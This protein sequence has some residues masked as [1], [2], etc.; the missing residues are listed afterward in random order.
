M[1]SCF[2][3][4]L[5]VVLLLQ[6]LTIIF[7]WFGL[8]CIRIFIIHLLPVRSFRTNKDNFWLTLN[9][10]I[11]LPIY[12]LIFTKFSI[13]ACRISIELCKIKVLYTKIQNS[14][15]FTSNLLLTF[16]RL[17]MIKRLLVSGGVKKYLK[18]KSFKVYVCKNV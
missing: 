12:C 11:E 4:S 3:Q 5:S 14:H 17:I 15:E 2:C 6:F 16:L 18:T 10:R 13:S 8:R 1:N 7:F 9:H